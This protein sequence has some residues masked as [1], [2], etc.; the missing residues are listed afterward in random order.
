MGIGILGIFGI[1]GFILG[2]GTWLRGLGSGMILGNSS[3]GFAIRLG[4][5][6]GFYMETPIAIHLGICDLILR[7]TLESMLGFPLGFPL[8]SGKAFVP[9]SLRSLILPSLG[10]FPVRAFGEGNGWLGGWV[11]GGKMGIGGGRYSW[12]GKKET[13]RVYR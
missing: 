7:L 13:R 5:G 9:P 6:L 3:L 8:Q 12:R 4:F 10:V 11:G 1:L 2:F